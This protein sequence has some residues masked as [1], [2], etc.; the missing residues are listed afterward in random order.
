MRTVIENI[1][2]SKW[3]QTNQK[4]NTPRNLEKDDHKA[5]LLLLIS[6]SSH[7]YCYGDSF[8]G[9]GHLLNFQKI[10]NEHL[11]AQGLA[12]LDDH[13]EQAHISLWSNKWCW[14]KVID[15]KIIIN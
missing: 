9:C 11:F 7:S 3:K 6:L 1:L 14:G 12:A 10:Y 4:K 15:G 5:F 2:I 13:L 8:P